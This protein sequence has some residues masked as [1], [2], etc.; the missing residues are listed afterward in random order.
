MVALSSL[1]ESPT[2]FHQVSVMQHT[3]AWLSEMQQGAKQLKSH[4]YETYITNSV[5]I[6]INVI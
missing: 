6:K 2:D 5:D 3:L 1:S 4:I